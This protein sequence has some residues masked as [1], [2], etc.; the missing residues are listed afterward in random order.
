MAKLRELRALVLRAP[1]EAPVRTSFGVMN[2]RPML[3]VRLK[4]IDGVMGWGE[5]WCNFPSVGA[6]HRARLLDSVFSGLLN[7]ADAG[8]P[9]ALFEMLTARTRVLA[10]QSGEAGPIAQCIS[11][12]DVALWDLKARKERKPLYKL[13][14]GA[15]P[16][17]RVY[18]SGLNPDKPEVLA[19]KMFD[20]GYRAFKLKVAFGLERDSANLR[21]IRT[22]V[23]SSCALMADANQGWN[24]AEA[25]D[26]VRALAEFELEW[27]EEPLR[28]DAPRQEWETLAQRTETP[29]ALG[30]N[31]TSRSAFDEA[32]G[33]TSAAVIQ[34]DVSKWGG[35]SACLPIAIQARR[36]GK[37]FCPHF[38]GGAIGLAASA[39]FLAAV[40]GDGRLEIDANPNPLRTIFSGPLDTI[41]DGTAVLDDRPGLSL[42]PDFDALAHY[43]TL[44]VSAKL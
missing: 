12:I 4:D 40:G 38:L 29:L 7:G 23:G 11:G 25:S 10:I 39:H 34:P 44:E 42:E 32:I 16:A 35:L 15:E 5:I 21:A 9:A 14:G 31:L 1:I 2:D 30:E 43:R 22:T 37:R 26:A 19:R 41:V 17:I 18:A 20:A 27:L 3:V 33:G 6:E 8:D 13:L 36:A 24:L 28:A